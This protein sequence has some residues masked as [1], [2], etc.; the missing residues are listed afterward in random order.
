MY[1]GLMLIHLL[2]TY[3]LIIFC[4]SIV[5]IEKQSESE[6]LGTLEAA[7]IEYALAYL[8]AAQC[9]KREALEAYEGIGLGGPCCA[10]LPG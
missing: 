10:G 6:V 7:F 1:T 9:L 4:L 3:L 8:E 5:T 2:L